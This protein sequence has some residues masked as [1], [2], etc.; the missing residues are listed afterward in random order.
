MKKFSSLF[1][2]LMVVTL[3]SLFVMSVVY[4]ATTIG[5]N[6][7]TG[8]TLNVTGVATL[9][10][11][12]SSTMATSSQYLSITGTNTSGSNN[13]NLNYA[14]GDL[15]VADGFEVDGGSWLNSVTTTDSLKI[16]GYATVTGDLIVNG[17]TL[18]LTSQVPTTTAGIFS[19]SVTATSTLSAGNLE[20]ALSVPGCLELV[21]DSNAPAYYHCWIDGAGTGLICSAGRCAD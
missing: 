14:G 2:S 5:S 16:G 7:T 4:A 13:N 8:G 18:D 20:D 11:G 12:A 19:R 10:G 1:Q 15:Y 21:K 3:A 9:T 6:I 17:G